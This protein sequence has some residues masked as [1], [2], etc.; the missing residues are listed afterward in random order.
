MLI[1]EKPMQICTSSLQLSLKARVR[2]FSLSRELPQLAQWTTAILMDIMVTTT[3][4]MI[5]TITKRRRRER[6]LKE[7]R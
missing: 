3:D 1:L 2:P 6:Q 4:I 5:I 7:V